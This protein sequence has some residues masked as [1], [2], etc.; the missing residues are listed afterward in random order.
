MSIPTRVHIPF[1]PA[2]SMIWNYVKNKLLEQIKAVAFIILYLLAF[3]MLILGEYPQNAMQISFGIGM[4]ILGLA[5]FMEGL[6]LGLM[7]LGERVGIQLPQKTN[8]YLIMLFG[9]LLG[10]GATLAEPAIST[11]Q[12]AGMT[13]TP[14]E[15]PLLYRMLEVETSYLVYAVGAGVG[16]AVAA[17]MARFYYGISIKKFIYILIPLLTA[18]SYYFYKD[19]NLNQILNL[20]WDTGGVTTG[21]VTVPLVLAMGIGISKVSKK[22]NSSAASGFGVVTLASLFPVLGVLILGFWLN[23]TTPKPVKESDFFALNHRTEALKL[24]PNEEALKSIAFRRGT[25]EGRKAFFNYNLNNYENALISLLDKNKCKE[26]LGTELTYH[27][28]LSQKASSAEQSILAKAQATNK[29]MS[30]I[31]NNTEYTK[32]FKEN[33]KSA[34][35]AVVPLV[36]L[37]SFVLVIIL[38]DRPKHKD[39]V[40]LGIFLSLIGMGVLTSGIQLGFSSLGDQVGRPLPLLF[41]SPTHHAGKIILQPFDKSSVI[42]AYNLKGEKKQYF[43]L[44]GIGNN[45][46]LQEFI[47]EQF[48]E[49]NKQYELILKKQSKFDAKLTLVGIALVFLFAFGM[50]YGSTVAEPALNALGNTVEGITVGTIKRKGVVKTVAV[51]VGIGLLVGVARII[52]DINTI[53]LLAP[54][55]IITV[56]L[57]FFVDDEYAGIAW[58]SGGVTTGPI[59]VPLVLAMGLGI[60]GGLNIVDGFGIVAMASIFP[61]LAMLIY[62]ISVQTNQHSVLN[63]T[64]EANK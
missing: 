40:I 37:L 48:N 32:V 3:K 56:I 26:L 30:P 47:P 31:S 27:E 55:Y 44:K 16:V 60:G 39:E 5:L 22:K 49:N 24:I 62:G 11:L 8:I 58:D 45:L 10:F 29:I 61:I 19:P 51:G 14:W 25:E 64:E 20:A 46:K 2:M 12:H 57:T 50:G 18:L 59:T 4:V 38:K 7:P 1:R 63:S 6:Y 52:Y 35:T 33:S 36:L 54:A 13:V 17:G 9:L 42:T 23:S 43:Y 41:Q 21:P 15:A 34:F 53:Y 28:W